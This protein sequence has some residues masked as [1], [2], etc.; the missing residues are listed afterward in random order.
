MLT[1]F[2]NHQWKAFW[3]S[4]NRKG[5]LATQIVLIFFILYFLAVAVGLGFGMAHFLLQLFPHQDIIKSFNGIILYYFAF[6]LVMRFQLQELPTLS[7]IPYLHLKIPKNKIIGFLNIKALF[8]AFNLWPFL[9]F[10]PFCFTKISAQYGGFV[11]L[12]YLVSILSIAVF[13]NYFVLYIK[14]KSI[15]NLFYTIAGLLIIAGFAVLEYYKVI[16]IMK[17]SDAVFR[18]IVGQPLSALVFSIAAILIFK[19]NSHYLGRNLYVE[20]LG[21]D[22][23]KKVSTDYP[24]LNRFGR[25]GELAALE[26]KLILR[27][28]R[29][30][31]SFFMGFLFL[32]YGFLFYK[33]EVIAANAFGQMM[34]GAIFMTGISIL[35]YGQFMFAWQSAHFDGLLSNKVN[36]RDFI[37]AKFLLFTIACT[38]ITLLASFYGFLSPKL[39]LLH[40]TAYLYNVGFGTVMVLYLANFNYKRI[41]INKSATFNY[42]GISANQWLLMFPYALT[43]ILIYL[44]FGLLG[45]PYLG[46]ILVSAFGLMMILMRGYWVNFITRKFEQQRYKI[47]EGF[48]A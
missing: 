11:T 32:L 39:L 5:S 45:K 6:D 46:L 38:L 43:P 40:L 10:L 15:T 31:V 37:K 36:F 48:R 42:Q 23:E 20:E 26:L 8:S 21:S 30:R 16:S 3:R 29:S 33:Q 4:R 12:M 41:D 22:N 44:P 25:T 17:G 2:L 14:R 27:H 1:T 13:N 47:A 7:V 28:K 19:M 34:F 9:L 35:M 24:F 18:I